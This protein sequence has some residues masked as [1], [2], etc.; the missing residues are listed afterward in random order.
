MF[1]ITKKLKSRNP[2]SG[3][4]ILHELTY[5]EKL[6]IP[7]FFYNVYL[8]FNMYSSCLLFVYNST[9]KKTNSAS[10]DSLLTNGRQ[11]NKRLVLLTVG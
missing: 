2:N 7:C 3:P 9:N 10:R 6:N 8:L 4:E 11:G 1:K 5:G